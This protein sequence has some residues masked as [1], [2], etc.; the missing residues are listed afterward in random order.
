MKS[1]KIKFTHA[2][3]SHYLKTVHQKKLIIYVAYTNCY[4]RFIAGAGAIA[5][6]NVKEAR[7]EGKSHSC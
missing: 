5:A 2:I 4:A 3:I 1:R 6:A 7:V